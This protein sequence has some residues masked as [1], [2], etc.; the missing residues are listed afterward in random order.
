MGVTVGK[1]VKITLSADNLHRLLGL[2]DDVRIVA[3]QRQEDPVRAFVVIEG[4]SLP[5]RAGWPGGPDESELAYRGDVESPAVWHPIQGA[6]REGARV[7][8][9]DWRPG[10]PPRESTVRDVLGAVQVDS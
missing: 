5:S 10:D 2:P 4:D 1:R 9:G 8:W 7:R 3:V 6:G